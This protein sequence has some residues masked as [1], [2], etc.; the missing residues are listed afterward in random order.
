M[1]EGAVQE[2]DTYIMHD[3]CPSFTESLCVQE[4]HHSL[5]KRVVVGEPLPVHQGVVRG[6]AEDLG[7]PHSGRPS[8][9]QHHQ[10]GCQLCLCTFPEVS[11]VS[12]TLSSGAMATVRWG[13]VHEDPRMSD[14]GLPHL[15]RPSGLQHQHGGCQLCL[16]TIP[17]DDS[18]SPGNYGLGCRV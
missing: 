10:G 5:G 11:S 12:S 13:F 8:G 4:P 2:L 17:K 6:L 14:L 16:C 7:L 1:Q 3:I 18:A 15:G 9:L